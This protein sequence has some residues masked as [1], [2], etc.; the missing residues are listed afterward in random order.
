[1]LKWLTSLL[2]LERKA[3]SLPT[4]K[5]S[6]EPLPVLETGM[7]LAV[8]KRRK[9]LKLIVNL[10]G[11]PSELS[12]EY[13]NSLMHALVKVREAH[14]RVK[15]EYLRYRDD[16][17]DRRNTDL[18][19]EKLDVSLAI[20][21]KIAKE[22]QKAC[23][24]LT[25]MLEA[26][27][28]MSFASDQEILAHTL[29]YK[30]SGEIISLK[31]IVERLVDSE[32]VLLQMND[33]TRSQWTEEVKSHD[34]WKPKVDEKWPELGRDIFSEFFSIPFEVA[35][36]GYHYQLRDS[37]TEERETLGKAI[38]TLFEFYRAEAPGD[39][40]RPS[41]GAIFNVFNKDEAYLIYLQFTKS[42]IWALTGAFSLASQLET[43]NE[44]LQESI[45][46]ITNF[47]DKRNLFFQA[48]GDMVFSTNE[49][50]DRYYA[51]VSVTSKERHE[52]K[53]AMESLLFFT[54]SQVEKDWDKEMFIQFP[55]ATSLSP[56]R[57]RRE[58]GYLQFTVLQKCMFTEA[59]N[60]AKALEPMPEELRESLTLLANFGA[61]QME[62]S[63]NRS[64]RGD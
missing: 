63:R 6:A 52:F 31:E 42:Q 29:F 4:I 48:F 2:R 13:Q 60:R 11:T 22:Y 32:I 43:P 18:Y 57:D 30:R 5:D 36:R 15:G 59:I 44:K 8:E 14:T 53:K 23:E 39:W 28:I 64:G 7:D 17:Y 9:E 49:A 62:R 21:Q 24:V 38:E 27:P 56:S 10:E 16:A 55:V 58:E 35:E 50:N 26:Y 37:K 41:K 61:K 45:K 40:P 54:H 34:D 25:D 51:R 3:E 19:S 1:M 33:T 20:D 12:S 47:C 46:V